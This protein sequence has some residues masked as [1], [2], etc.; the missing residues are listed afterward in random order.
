MPELTTITACEANDHFDELLGTVEMEGR[1]FVVTERGRA[2]ARLVP[3]E[4]EDCLTPERNSVVERLRASAKPLGIGRL[5]RD[6]L[7]ERG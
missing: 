7:H 5:D 1:G 6:E 2:V 4:A 3:A